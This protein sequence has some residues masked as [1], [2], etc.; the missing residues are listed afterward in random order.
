MGSEHDAANTKIGVD[1]IL[2]DLLVQVVEEKLDDFPSVTKQDIESILD[3]VKN[4][5]V[6]GHVRRPAESFIEVSRVGQIVKWN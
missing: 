5:L 1:E 6:N 2:V 3:G 4:Q